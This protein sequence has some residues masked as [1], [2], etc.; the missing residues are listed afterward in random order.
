MCFDHIAKLSVA[1]E[2]KQAVK[3][4]RAAAIAAKKA[5]ATEGAK[6]TVTVNVTVNLCIGS[7]V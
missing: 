1:K 2:Q 5:K 4:K 6:N 7:N 3:D